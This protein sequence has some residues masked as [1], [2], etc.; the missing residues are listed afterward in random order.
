MSKQQASVDV[1]TGNKLIAEF[2][3]AKYLGKERS[4]G[5]NYDMFDFPESFPIQLSTADDFGYKRTGYLGFHERWDWLMIVIDDIK[6]NRRFTV[7]NLN[8]VSHPSYIRYL[9][10]ERA[11][12]NVS[13]EQ[14]FRAVVQ[15][16]IWY[17]TQTKKQ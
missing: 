8:E 5:I 12:R 16:I 1:L 13:I 2:M 6:Y 11:F 4:A 10:I 14:C 7:T 3:G 9:A 15:F 17:N